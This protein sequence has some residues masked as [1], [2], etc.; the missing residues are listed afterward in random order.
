MYARLEK[1]V[2]QIRSGYWF[3]PAVMALGALLLA[4]VLVAIDVKLGDESL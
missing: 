4:I 1:L 2:D 3:V